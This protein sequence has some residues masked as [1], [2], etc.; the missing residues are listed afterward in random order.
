MSDGKQTINPPGYA[1][2]ICPKCGGSIRWSCGYTG[3]GFAHCEYAQTSS[4]VFQ[5]DS[6]HTVTFCD[7]EGYCERRTDGKVEIYFYGPIQ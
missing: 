5:L 4:R 6:M 7:W 2:Y 3:F 1:K